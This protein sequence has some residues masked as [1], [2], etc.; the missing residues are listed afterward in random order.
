MGRPDWYV[1]MGR[2]DWYVTM[3]NISLQRLLRIYCPEHSGV[4]GN[5]R[6]DKTGGK[7][8]IGQKLLATW[9]I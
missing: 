2:P 8:V 1:T 7:K 5:D 9:K 6:A 3:F 4:N